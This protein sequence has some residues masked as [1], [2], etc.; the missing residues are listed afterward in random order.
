MAQAGIHGLVGMAV[1]KWT[2]KKE[3]L[4]LGIVFGSMLPDMDALAVA[5]AT[6]SGKDTHGL[7]R[8]WS[9]SI[10]LILGLVLVFYF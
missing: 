4:M 10:L 5:Y 8:T 6:L 9:H 7:H 1:R 2:P 3:W